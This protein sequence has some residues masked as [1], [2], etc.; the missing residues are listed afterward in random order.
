MIVNRLSY[1]LLLTVCVAHLP[2]RAHATTVT[3]VNSAGD[4]SRN[5]TPLV[6]TTPVGT[7]SPGNSIAFA[8][9]NNKL[10]FSRANGQFEVDQAGYNYGD[11]AFANNTML[12]GGGGFQG[13]G[14][15]GSITL[16][17][18]VPVIQFGL[19][20][21]DFIPTGQTYAVQFFAR[22]A[23]GR[24]ISNDTNPSYFYSGGCLDNSCLSFEGLTVSGDAIST[25]M[26]NDYPNGA[27]SDDLMF[28]NIQYTTVG[29]ALQAPAAVTPEPSSLVL[30]GTGILGVATFGRRAASRLGKG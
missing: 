17:F 11:T 21:E 26:F 8:N 28:G 16:T 3:Q 25:V 23:A 1:L 7:I 30:L 19:N 5:G 10:T 9:G 12:V 24:P 29:T 6:I 13:P 22:D 2:L 18:A 14:D 4:L 20:I 15:G 27:G